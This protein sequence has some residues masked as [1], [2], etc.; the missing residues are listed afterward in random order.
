MKDV[1]N[2]MHRQPVQSTCT[3]NLQITDKL[4][5]QPLIQA[6]HLLYLVSLKQIPQA[7]WF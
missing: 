3:A 1:L 4:P 6:F 5:M 2:P 7:G